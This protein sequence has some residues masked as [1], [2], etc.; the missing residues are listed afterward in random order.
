MLD[1]LPLYISVAF[2]LTTFATL[3]LFYWTIKNSTSLS[4]RNK[5]GFIV[6]VLVIW[7]IIQAILTLNNFYK[8]GTNEIPPKILVFGVLPPIITIVVLFAT[9][10]GRRF[11][12]NLP[13]KNITYLN[14][15]RIPVEFILLTLF[16][17]K[18]VPELMTFEGRNFDIVSGITA[19][20]VSYF[21]I[22]K[23]KLSRNVLLLW[24]FVCLALLAN[25]VIHALLSAPSPFQKLA[26]DQP[27]VAILNFPFS[28]LP[29]F[30]VPVVLFG[31]L[32]SIRQLTK[33]N[34]NDRKSS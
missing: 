28:W 13:L 15:I 25:I 30:V 2:A 7:L 16:I 26:F 8:T 18:V 5:A 17:N 24:N 33:S 14:F 22:T 29:S 6:T 1:N 19:P 11:I 32:V 21:G 3:A 23:G 20:F 12:D 27:N 34:V 31:H 10:K 9:A 4:I